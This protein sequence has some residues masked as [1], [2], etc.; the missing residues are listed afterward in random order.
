MQIA[1]DGN[2]ALFKTEFIQML[3]YDLLKSADRF[4]TIV[5]FTYIAEREILNIDIE[6]EMTY[7]I[8]LFHYN[9]SLP[10]KKVLTN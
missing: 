8:Q 4:I 1:L 10:A 9:Y 2:H 7:F 5:M 3:W 6:A